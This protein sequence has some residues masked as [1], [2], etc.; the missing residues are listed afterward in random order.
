[1]D[2]IQEIRRFIEADNLCKKA[3]APSEEYR[4]NLVLR[5]E[6]YNRTPELLSYLLRQY[7]KK[8][9]IIAYSVELIEDLERQLDT[10]KQENE[11]LRWINENLSDAELKSKA[12]KEKI[13]KAI[14][15]LEI[16]ADVGERDVMLIAQET[17][18]LIRP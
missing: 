13:H 2:K 14:E 4:N 17:L 5:T 6:M 11:W 3:T 16:C 15:A 7:D 9:E 8:C 1:M 18:S 10:A 12:Y